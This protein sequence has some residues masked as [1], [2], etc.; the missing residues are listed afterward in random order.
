MINHRDA[1]KAMID[2]GYRA[3]SLWSRR[4]AEI[5]RELGAAVESADAVGPQRVSP[6]T[7]KPTA[8]EP[9]QEDT[10]PATSPRFC[11]WPILE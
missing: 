2:T 7:L 11:D 6:Q 1:E 10:G 4:P 9:N 3:S 5:P 8:L